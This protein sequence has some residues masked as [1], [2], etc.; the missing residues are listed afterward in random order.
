MTRN[1]SAIAPAQVARRN[2]RSSTHRVGM[3]AQHC[4]QNPQVSWPAGTNSCYE[5]PI[6]VD[7]SP[8][9]TGHRWWTSLSGDNR[10]HNAGVSLQRDPHFAQLQ[11]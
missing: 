11:R 5:L 3:C 6:T 7:S 2:S 8:A 4:G 10:G 1:T 9:D